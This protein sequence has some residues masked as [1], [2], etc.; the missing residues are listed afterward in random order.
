MTIKQNLVTGQGETFTLN[1]LFKDSLGAPVNLTGHSVD[2]NVKKAGVGT[3]VGTYPAEVDANGNINIVVEDEVT[4]L[5]P[6]GKLAYVVKHTTPDG[7]EKWLLYG[8]LT[9]LDGVS[10]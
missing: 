9:V 1:M 6:K 4:D 10:V 5:W 3:E 7:V 8:A 2:L